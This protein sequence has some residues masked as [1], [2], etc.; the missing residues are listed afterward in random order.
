[1]PYPYG[2]FN[3]DMKKI[4]EKNGFLISFRFGPSNYA[5][6]KADRFAF[7]R[8]KLNGNANIDNLKN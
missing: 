5:T 3:E 1:M 4:L 6:R 7:P 2:S 8:I